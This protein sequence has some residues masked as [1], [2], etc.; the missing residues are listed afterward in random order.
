M[1]YL[2]AT[3]IRLL[4]AVVPT[5]KNGIEFKQEGILK[6]QRGLGNGD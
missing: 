6:L 1:A 5:V 2:P 3:A 4:N